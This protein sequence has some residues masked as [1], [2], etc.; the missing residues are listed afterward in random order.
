[1]KQLAQRLG[2]HQSLLWRYFPQEC[3][4]IARRNEECEQQRRKER[5]SQVCEE[6][7]QAVLT[8]HAQKALIFQ[9]CQ[10]VVKPA[11][12][13][14]WHPILALQLHPTEATKP[15]QQQVDKP[16]RLGRAT[17]EKLYTQPVGQNSHL[18]PGS[19]I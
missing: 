4:L 14:G 2:H 12:H 5:E 18:S 8:L 11:H 17:R 15:G 13:P 9:D 7:R 19:Y 10:R 6:V 16:K 3:A 1:M